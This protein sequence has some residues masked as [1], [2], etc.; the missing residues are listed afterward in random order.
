MAQ[1]KNNRQSGSLAVDEKIMQQNTNLSSDNQYNTS[2]YEKKEIRKISKES[3]LALLRCSELMKNMFLS[4]LKQAG[5]DSEE[6]YE[7]MISWIRNIPENTPFS[8]SKDE[9]G[10][11][12]FAVMQS[13]PVE[14]EDAL[15]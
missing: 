15:E 1:E 5:D 14:D 9:L 3:Y 13:V 6:S 4:L 11:F 2:S 12:N 8:F 7:K 10:C